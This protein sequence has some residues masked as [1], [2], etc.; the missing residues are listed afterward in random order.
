MFQSFNLL[1]R[2]SALEN[3]ELP[4]LYA[5][6]PARERHAARRARRW[7]GSAWATRVDHHPNQLSGGQQQRVAIARALVT[8]PQVILAD[9]PTGNLDSRTSIEIMALFQELGEPASPSCSSRTSPTSPRFAARVIIMKDGR[10]ADRRRQQPPTR[11]PP[12]RASA[13]SAPQA[14]GRSRTRSRRSDRAADAARRG[15][16]RCCATSCA[17]S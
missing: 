5:G 7:S 11:A 14:A 6:V 10:R 16:A 17:R 12:W 3:V 13:S 1:S 15:A 9:E 8:A 4:L 2:T